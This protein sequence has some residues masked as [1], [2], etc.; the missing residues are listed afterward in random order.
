MFQIFKPKKAEKTKNRVW[1]KFCPTLP[2]VEKAVRRESD[3]LMANGDVNAAIYLH[4]VT[5]DLEPVVRAAMSS[6]SLTDQMVSTLCGAAS[7]QSLYNVPTGCSYSAALFVTVK[8]KKT[9]HCDRAD[10]T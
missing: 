9:K 10:A 3:N 1:L 5:G 2:Q 7:G 8:E 4:Q 6:G